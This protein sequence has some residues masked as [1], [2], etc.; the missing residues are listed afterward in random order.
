MDF[1]SALDELEITLDTEI[2]IIFLKKRYHKLALKYHP[3]KNKDESSK[4]KFQRINDAY[5]YLLNIFEEPNSN[6]YD[7]VDK[8]DNFDYV[9]LLTTFITTLFNQDIMTTILKDIVSNYENIT[10]N[11]LTNKFEQLD[12]QKSTEL[13]L[14]L[15][16]YKDIFHINS[17][18]L[19]FVSSIFSEKYKNDR[20]FILYPQINDILNHNIYK[21]QYDNQLYLV[22]LWHNEIYFDSP[23]KEYDV[24]VL[25][26]PSLPTNTHIDENNNIDVYYNNDE[27]IRVG[28]RI[29]SGGFQQHR[30]EGPRANQ[31]LLLFRLLP[32]NTGPPHSHAPPSMRLPIQRLAFKLKEE[33]SWG[34]YKQ[35]SGRLVHMFF[36]DLE[37]EHEVEQSFFDLKAQ[38]Q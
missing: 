9:S 14:L 17:E 16:K 12:K 20:L 35:E 10:L 19:Q 4:N 31:V 34:E 37:S 36:I 24:I 23:N 21:L 30:P 13:F 7:N 1:Q 25:C 6:A 15:I 18:T 22:P 29:D 26:Q 8:S 33:K 5:Y 28:Q 38:L 32:Q 3:D 2:D 27:L 11:F